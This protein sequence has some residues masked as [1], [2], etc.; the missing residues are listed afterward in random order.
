MICDHHSWLL[1]H[2][3]WWARVGNKRNGWNEYKTCW[4]SPQLPCNLKWLPT[5]NFR[6]SIKD[7]FDLIFFSF[8]FFTSVRL[9]DCLCACIL[10]CFVA[11]FLLQIWEAYDASLPS[12][13]FRLKAL[14]KPCQTSF[15]TITLPVVEPRMKQQQKTKDGLF[16]S[17]C[18][19]MC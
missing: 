15:C 6:V 1:F 16:C 11:F 13:T 18:S 3:G 9:F 2:T 7:Y 8:S 14:H 17:T 5:S 19:L 12:F 4:G 10:R